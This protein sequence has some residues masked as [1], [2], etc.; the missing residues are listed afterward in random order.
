ML[1]EVITVEYID[2]EELTDHLTAQGGRLTV[3]QTVPIINQ[4]Y[5]LRYGTLPIVRATGG[6]DDTIA[7]YA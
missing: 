5:S 3:A 2:G 7:N 6:L 4:I 1:Y